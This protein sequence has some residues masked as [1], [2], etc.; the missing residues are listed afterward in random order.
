MEKLNSVYKLVTKG[1]CFI[2]LVLFS[3]PLAFGFFKDI[4]TDTQTQSVRGYLAFHSPPKLAFSPLVASA[5]RGT[6]LRLGNPISSLTASSTDDVNASDQVEFP[7]TAYGDSDTNQS[8]IYQIPKISEEPVLESS[9]PNLLPPAD[10]FVAPQTTSYGSINTTDELMKV[11]EEEMDSTRSTNQTGFQ[12]L[13]PYTLERGN[14]LMKS[15]ATYTRMQR[16]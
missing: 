1:F 2:S 6:L 16:D 10:P 8:A 11:F 5:D 12:F 14:M 3:T 15:G 13:P 9:N 7:L 4:E